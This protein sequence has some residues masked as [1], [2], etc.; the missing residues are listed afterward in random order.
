MLDG[1]RTRTDAAQFL[2]CGD[3]DD[4]VTMALLQLLDRVRGAGVTTQIGPI[5][6]NLDYIACQSFAYRFGTSRSL[7]SQVPRHAQE[8]DAA[9]V[10]S[11]LAHA[12]PYISQASAP[13]LDLRVIGIDAFSA[14]PFFKVLELAALERRTAPI[15]VTSRALSSDVGNIEASLSDRLP[16]ARSA[17][18][19]TAQQ[20]TM[21]MARNA[22]P[23]D[24]LIAA[25][26]DAEILAALGHELAGSVW[27]A[28]H[29]DVD[30]QS[31]RASVEAAQLFDDAPSIEAI[32]RAAVDALV[33]ADEVG[34]AV[35]L[36]DAL[37]RTLEDRLHTE[38]AHP[39]ARGTASVSEWDFIAAVYARLGQQPR[40]RMLLPNTASLTRSP[41]TS[42]TA[43]KLV[44]SA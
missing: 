12:V 36:C 39:S 11:T 24:L 1:G 9:R 26:A 17:E 8:V 43:L 34:A 19:L 20:A 44:H 7:G 16:N 21:L 2:L 29:L 5:K 6:P 30:A 32:L 28:S 25:Q 10:W 13:D 33:I 27:M 23:G 18:V 38:Q 41:Q 15:I 22:F 4:A 31:A 40:G 35:Q 3:G 42:T 37:Y 14:D